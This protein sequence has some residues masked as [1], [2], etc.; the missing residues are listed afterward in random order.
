MAENK[1]IDVFVEIPTGSQ[2]KYEFDK[3]KGVFKLD[4]VLFSSQ[5]YPAEY[6]YI[7][8]TLALDGDP[9]DA[10]VLVTN[11]TFPGCV[12]ESRVIGFLNMIDDGEEDQKLLAVPTEDPRF[13]DVHTLDDVPQH[14]LEE[15]SHFFKTYKDLQGK[16][17]EIGAWE[18]VEAANKLIDDCFNRHQE[19]K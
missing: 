16:K 4:R 17:T 3:E 14:K 7:D 5:F 13:K 6:G 10:L 1:V 11:P 18:G 15:I 12:I 19:D 2:N 8:D 9:L